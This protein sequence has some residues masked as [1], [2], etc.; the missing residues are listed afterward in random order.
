VPGISVLSRRLRC[1]ASEPS[2]RAAAWRFTVSAYLPDGD[3]YVVAAANAGA[4]ASPAWYRNLVANPGVTVEVGTETFGGIAA[5][6]AGAE[7]RI[8]YERC[9]CGWRDTR[10]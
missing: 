1:R 6:A 5:V 10:P 8:L 9:A 2:Y 4:P 3:R 7:R